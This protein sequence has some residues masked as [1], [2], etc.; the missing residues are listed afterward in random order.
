MFEVSITETAN[1]FAPSASPPRSGPAG[2]ARHVVD[3][4]Y[5]VLASTSFHVHT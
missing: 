4:K 3:D 1:L 2:T 5:K